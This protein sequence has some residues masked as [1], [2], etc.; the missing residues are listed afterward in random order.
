M[1]LSLD[2]ILRLIAAALRQATPL[3]LA[4]IGITISE[5][6]GVIHLS[7]EGTM[8]M[9]ALAGVIVSYLTGSALL[10]LAGAL[11]A[12]VIFGLIM[13]VADVTLKANQIIVGFGINFL[14]AGLSP[15]LLERL[16]GSR[17]RSD[18]VAG[19]PRLDAPLVDQV[20]LLGPI[21]G[22]QSLLFFVT[23]AIVPIAWFLF[24]HSPIGLRLRMVGEHPA[25][26]AT[27]GINVKLTRYTAV[28]VACALCALAGAELS[29][30]QISLFGRSM[31]AGRGFIAVAANVVGG[32][33]PL[34]G[35]LAS[36]LFG[37]AD[38]LQLRLQGGA[39][40]NHFI[41]M[42]PYV[43]TILVVSGLGGLH[44]PRA[45]GVPFDPE[46]K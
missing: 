9:S 31:I 18:I 37:T 10:G 35:V 27:A 3:A 28:L 42:L 29:L 7:A 19:L 25:A 1:D 30:G 36:L 33:R 6:A 23:L 21:L 39:M 26:A 22:G 43:L 14:A 46:E 45:L 17:G 2:Q 24:H 20:P 12:G 38:A 34:G 4:T 8:L 11:L 41:Q 5:A 44:P 40:P 32:W 13:A 15:V 16:W